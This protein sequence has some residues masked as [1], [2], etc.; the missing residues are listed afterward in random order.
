[1]IDEYMYQ[2]TGEEEE[3]ASTYVGTDNS[4]AVESNSSSY[5]PSTDS[6]LTKTV[7]PVFCVMV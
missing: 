3:K 1:M 6:T 2:I 7:V 5:V 4:D